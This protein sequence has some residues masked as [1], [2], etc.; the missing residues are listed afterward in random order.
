M[1]VWGGGEQQICCLPQRDIEKY[2]RKKDQRERRDEGKRR[3][4]WVEP[5]R[6][7]EKKK[8]DGG[9]KDARTFKMQGQYRA[10]RRRR[11][12]NGGQEVM[13]GQKRGI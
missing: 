3:A 12:E 7:T 9:R 8:E 1:Y 2:E 6:S 11:G 13:S 5:G 4:G 10:D